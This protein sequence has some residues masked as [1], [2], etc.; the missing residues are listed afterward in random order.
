MAI[1][2]RSSGETSRADPD[3]RWPRRS[4]RLT[5]AEI[6]LLIAL[7]LIGLI[8]GA[9][10]AATPAERF[11]AQSVIAVQADTGS[12][13]AAELHRGQWR[14]AAEAA[15]VPAV[16]LAAARDAGDPKPRL[17][18]LE[19]RGLVA[20]SPGTSLLLIR[21]QDRSPASSRALADA[22][23]QQTVLFLRTVNRGNLLGTE[24]VQ[25]F[26]FESGSE[27][28]SAADSRFA[29]PPKHLSRQAPAE[30]G[31]FSL[32]SECG[33]AAGCGPHVQAQGPFSA[34][35][36]YRVGT[37]A[38]ALRPGT[39]ARLVLGSSSRDVAVGAT[40]TLPTLPT[41]RWQLLS[42]RWAPRAGST[43]AELAMQT[44]SRG[45]A[46]MLLD[47]VT[48]DEDRG[49]GDRQTLGAADTTLRTVRALRFAEGDRY[50]AVGSASS[51]GELSSETVPWALAGGFLGL[52]MSAA[53]LAG[54]ELARR[55]KHAQRQPHPDVDA[56]AGEL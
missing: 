14:T 24:R 35:S 2:R 9:A 55:R 50:A 3:G 38:R 4:R 54:A 16:L 17:E 34:L 49:V 41:L 11:V 31:S 19:D 12:P 13:D 1:R 20:G 53:A 8:A 10:V 6:A 43:S 45:A 23:A 52:A 51:V 33:A 22:V 36:S 46:T 42:V 15:R 21:A 29:V 44:M 25:S 5:S 27:G 26:S 28:W 30:S 47:G 7:P 56:V 48:V 39:R 40:V 32:R 37:Y 18:S